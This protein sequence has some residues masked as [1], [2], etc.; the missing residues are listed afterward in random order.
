MAAVDGLCDA[1]R[2]LLVMV[3]IQEKL[4]AA[5]SADD[6]VQLTRQGKLLLQAAHRLAV[7]V[8]GGA[9]LGPLNLAV[10][11][12]G[13]LTSDGASL[14]LGEGTLR[15]QER[16]SLTWTGH[17]QPPSGEP[18]VGVLRLAGAHFD[19]GEVLA[20]A[21]LR[22]TFPATAVALGIEPE[23]ID[24]ICEETMG[25]HHMTGCFGC[26][27]HCRAQYKIPEGPLAGRYDEGPE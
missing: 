12:T 10:D 19:L 2:S 11:Q 23:R 26:Q 6:R 24:E 21:Q 5:M 18:P 22:C 25:P 16:S 20:L 4:L 14:R 17:V 8:L 7:P 27:V 1:G 3:D 13:A 15:L 9:T